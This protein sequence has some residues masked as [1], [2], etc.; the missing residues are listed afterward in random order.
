MSGPP[1][2]EAGFRDFGTGDRFCVQW[3]PAEGDVRGAL[4]HIPAFGEEM[5]KSRRTVAVAARHMAAAGY[6][7][8]F[9]DAYGTGDSPGEFGE[10][11]W[12]IWVDDFRAAA[13]ELARTIGGPVIPW[14]HRAG[15][16]LLPEMVAAGANVLLWQPVTSGDQHLT[17]I[18]RLKVA[19]DTFAGHATPATTKALRGQ[20]DAG[21]SLEIAGYVLNPELV[22]P[23]A[24]RTLSSWSAKPAA[25]DW[26]ETGPEPASEPS[27]GS[28][29]AIAALKDLGIRV[30]YSHVVGEP[31]WMTLEIAENRAMGE[32]SVEVLEAGVAV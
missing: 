2:L 25:I 9:V 5:N 8:R 30:G 10:A 14:G 27:P 29:R 32:R 4:L 17:Q 6:I 7:V 16:L 31:F 28:A 20:L 11:T 12:R 3:A 23:L 26:I 15:C 24:Q 1:R 21:E 22:L 13:A 19:A 18:L